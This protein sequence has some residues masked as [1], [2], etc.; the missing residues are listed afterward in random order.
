VE[1][2]KQSGLTARDYAARNRSGPGVFRF[3]TDRRA[4][5]IVI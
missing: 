4:D 5:P 3:E 2:W 1:Q